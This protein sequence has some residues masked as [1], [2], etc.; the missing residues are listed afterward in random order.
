LI[1][2][3]SVVYHQKGLVLLNAKVILTLLDNQNQAFY[4]GEKLPLFTP[5]SPYIPEKS[6][7]SDEALVPQTCELWD[8]DSLVLSTQNALQFVRN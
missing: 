8:W 6:P 5:I 3:I 4:E 1:I 2:I 7:L